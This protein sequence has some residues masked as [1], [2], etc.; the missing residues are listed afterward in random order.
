MQLVKYNV[1][2]DAAAATSTDN[3]ALIDQVIHAGA[4]LT[5]RQP[6]CRLLDIKN[7]SFKKTAAAAESLRIQVVTFAGTANAID[8]ELE[9]ETYNF[10]TQEIQIPKYSTKPLRQQLNAECDDKHRY[11]NKNPAH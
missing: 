2:I 8:Y 7:G 5:S 4:A 9:F 1:V 11:P 6:I 10:S 3:I